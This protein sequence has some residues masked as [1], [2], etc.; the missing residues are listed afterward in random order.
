MNKPNSRQ[1]KPQKII[2]FDG[3]CHLCNRFVDFVIQQDPEHQFYFAPLQ[4]ITAQK[5]LGNERVQKLDSVIYS[6]GLEIFEKS[7]AVSRILKQL[8]PPYKILGSILSAFPGSARDLIYQ[9]VAKNRYQWFGEKDS[10]RI[11][12]ASERAQF[13][14]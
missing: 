6:E 4:G 8:P 11:P 5:L 7:D 10:C 14:D 2:F 9:L 13:L 1:E 12:T 3:V